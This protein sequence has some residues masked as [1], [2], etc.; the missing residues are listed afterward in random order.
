VQ[1][2][3][4]GEQEAAQ[5]IWVRLSA[6]ERWK[7]WPDCWEPRYQSKTREQLQDPSLLLGACIFDHLR[8]ALLREAVD[9]KDVHARMKALLKE[10]P[11]VNEGWRGQLF[12]D[13]TRTI[14]AEPPK[15]GSVEAL[16]LDL[17]GRPMGQLGIYEDPAGREILDR[18]LDAVPELIP[19]LQ[20]P[21]VTAHEEQAFMNAPASIAP[22]GFLAGRFLYHIVG[23]Q[24]SFPK[25]GFDTDTIRAWWEN[26][27]SPRLSF[28]VS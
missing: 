4:L 5:A 23:D 14:N 22:V 21:R 19:L 28:R 18:G 16:L 25:Y 7:D 11:K 10:F 8:N 20:D 13:L 12:E 9:R 24:P 26:C 3:A 17:A 6:A 1:A 15:P 2:A 27:P